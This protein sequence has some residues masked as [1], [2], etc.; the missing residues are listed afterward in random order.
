MMKRTIAAK[1]S[2]K[3]AT[4]SPRSPR[5]L[6]SW[7]AEGATILSTMEFLTTNAESPA[8]DDEDGA[9]T[10]STPTAANREEAI[11]YLCQRLSLP[12][13]QTLLVTY[14]LYHTA[15]YPRVS[16]D[17]EDLSN[18]MRVHP[19]RMMQMN[20]DLAQLEDLGYIVRNYDVPSGQG[21][22]M[23][24]EA[25]D[26]F[27]KN[28]S[29]DPQ[30]IIL[31]SNLD[32]LERVSQYI[33][34]GMRYDSN[35]LIAENI[36]RLMKR[37]SHLQLVVNLQKMSCEYQLYGHTADQEYTVTFGINST[38]VP[39]TYGI[40]GTFGEMASPDGYYD[41]LGGGYTYVLKGDYMLEDFEVYT[42]EKGIVRVEM[43]E[44]QE[45]MVYASVICSNAVCYNITMSTKYDKPHLAEDE[46]EEEVDRTYTSN[47]RV[48]ILDETESW[49]RIYFDVEAADRSDVAA[50]YFFAEESDP[51]IIIPEG[52]YYFDYTEE[53][54]TMLAN[55][56]I[57]GEGYIIPSYYGQCDEHGSLSGTL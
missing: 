21:W 39:G 29:F 26:A 52:T 6:A 20:N 27:V 23:S 43:D 34:E 8:S 47:D 11:E 53:P 57:T 5:S 54:G 13:I 25:Y 1:K 37:N 50:L 24:R 55:P 18:M 19:L 51:E 49:G 3:R 56:G 4:R 44:D 28:Q 22:T 35:G 17:M 46:P 10:D 2:P 41:L 45:I 15:R 7:T 38:V 9:E 31:T 30:S 48:V 33:D 32:F 14:L 12:R 36:T 16:C 42:V 40:D